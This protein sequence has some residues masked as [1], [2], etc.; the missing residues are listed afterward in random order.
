MP[1][2]RPTGRSRRACEAWCRVGVDGTLTNHGLLLESDGLE[3]SVVYASSESPE[4][5]ARPQ[6]RVCWVPCADTCPAG[7][8]P[9]EACAGGECRRSMLE[10]MCFGEAP[11]NLEICS[12][13]GLSLY[14][15][16]FCMRRFTAL[17]VDRRRRRACGLLRPRCVDERRVFL[18]AGFTGENSRVEWSRRVCRTAPVTV[19]CSTARVSVIRVSMA[20][21]ASRGRPRR[22]ALRRAPVTASVDS[23]PA[24][25]RS[26][27]AA[28]LAGRSDWVGGSRPPA[29]A[30]PFESARAPRLLCAQRLDIRRV[31]RSTRGALVLSNA[32][33][34]DDGHPQL[35][36][37][38]LRTP[39]PPRSPHR[40]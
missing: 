17:R 34:P 1:A 5:A 37:R 40:T 8:G 10:G 39:R 23:A 36:Y 32:R 19:C 27:T 3:T 16:C 21:S 20:R 4:P 35:L 29:A 6:L 11:V 9:G 33:Q 30:P 14:G 13:H 7:C 12:G 18:H 15:R 26:G 38:R 31:L 22:A 2:P 28:R 25:A 24:T